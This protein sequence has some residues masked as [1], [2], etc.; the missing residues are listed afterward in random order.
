MTGFTGLQNGARVVFG[1]MSPTKA[2]WLCFLAA[3]QE[4]P[5]SDL[6]RPLLD[7]AVGA[8]LYAAKHSGHPLPA[9]SLHQL[10]D[11]RT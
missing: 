7:P 11:T 3:L 9:S 8:A 10:A 5:A 4:R 6:R 1:R 2:F